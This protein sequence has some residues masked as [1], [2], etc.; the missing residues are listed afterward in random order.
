[1]DEKIDLSAVTSSIND[2]SETMMR[3]LYENPSKKS[4]YALDEKVKEK[5]LSDESIPFADRLTLCYGYGKIKKQFM[6]R[7]H[8]LELAEKYFNKG[9]MKFA[10]TIEKVDEDWFEFF[11]EKVENTSEDR[12]KSMWASLLSKQLDN[13]EN[14]KTDTISK[15][16]SRRFLWSSTSLS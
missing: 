7:K 6:R 4:E 14:G 1:M 10:E 16:S 2:F 11:I 15:K 8:V 3:V 5:I 9:T 13:I 12:F